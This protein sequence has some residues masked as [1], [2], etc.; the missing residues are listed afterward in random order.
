MY[1]IVI[2][3]LICLNFYHVGLFLFIF[4]CASDVARSR[5]CDCDRRFSLKEG[6][7][8]MLYLHHKT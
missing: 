5:G 7:D 3:P 6:G 4:L 8:N 1:A 2:Y